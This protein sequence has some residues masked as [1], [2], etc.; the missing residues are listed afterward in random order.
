MKRFFIT[1]LFISFL[2]SSFVEGALLRKKKEALDIIQQDELALK[3][4]EKA[5][6]AEEAGRKKSAAK[7]YKDIFKKYSNSYYSPEALYRAA[8]IRADQKKWKKAYETFNTIIVFYPNYGKFNDILQ[9]QFDIANTLATKK[10]SR[11]FGVIPFYNYDSAVKYFE[12]LVANAPYSDFAPLSL[13]QVGLIHKKRGYEGRAIDAFD[14]LVN[15]Y[16][17]SM[18]APDAYR[19]LANTFS[20]L[21]DGPK[22]DQGATRE[23]IANYK[24]YL[25]LFPDDILVET[26]EKGLQEMEDIYARSKLEMG[27]FYY[28]KRKNLLAARVFFNEAITVAPNSKSAFKARDY[29]AVMPEPAPAL[30]DGQQPVVAST[31][32]DSSGRGLVRRMQFW[33]RSQSDAPLPDLEQSQPIEVAAVEPAADNLAETAGGGDSDPAASE[34]GSK[35]GIVNKVIFWRKDRK[36]E[37]PVSKE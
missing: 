17:R 12:V 23:A 1:L 4:L 37:S 36:K 10:T 27:E 20:S 28:K 35:G 32:E 18:L 26:G 6:K 19:E 30:Q 16:P 8:N 15:N 14:R 11:F 9:E 31:Q 13:F 29:L 25:I 33:R 3:M 22:Y 24:D 7:Q 2:S 5:G 21:V 34:K